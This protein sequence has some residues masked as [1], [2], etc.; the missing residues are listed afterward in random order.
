MRLPDVH[1]AALLVLAVTLTAG[2][3][4][5]LATTLLPPGA[6]MQ[7]RAIHHRH[8]AAHR[9]PDPA[10]LHALAAPDLLVIDSDGQ[11][12]DRAAFLAS[13][14]TASPLADVA[15][16]DVQ[17]RLFGTAAVV[18]GTLLG[19]PH[20]GDARRVRCTDV[21]AWR[22]GRWTWV[23][24]QRTRI[25]NAVAAPASM[26]APPSAPSRWRGSDPVGDDATVLAALNEQ[27]VQA[28]RDADAGWYDAHLAPDYRVVS[29]DGS[30]QDRAAALVDFARPVFAESIAAFPLDKVR[31]NRIGELA[32]IHAENAY[33]LKD[34]RR[35]INRYTDIWIKRAG[36]WWCVAAHI[37][38]HTPPA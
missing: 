3:W 17:V 13:L 26:Q 18:H 14:P 30:L 32:M 33:T 28:F 22:E 4:P 15:Y 34:G 9:A 20:T 25:A 35:G 37:T 29:G 6:E 23:H 10:F 12:L 1:K 16:D 27:Y 19:H 11:W 24:G 5:V 2:T 31:I 7:L 8:V 21:Y 36:R 38:V